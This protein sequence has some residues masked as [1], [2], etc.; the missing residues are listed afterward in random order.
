VT[1]RL[2]GKVALI[3]GTGGGQ[4]RAAAV[5]FAEEGAAVVGCDLK[6]EGNRE[7]VAMVKAAGGEMT[8]MEPVD[9]G[10]PEQAQKWVEQAA[11]V[12]GRIDILYNNASAPKFAPIPDLSVEDW[13]FTI[14]NELD[15][16]FYVTKY[17]WP[18]LAERGG[19]IISTASVAGWVGTKDTGLGAHA[20]AK[21]GVLALSRVFAADGA[22]HG[23]RAVT[24][25]PGPIET[26]GTAELFA[27]PQARDYLSSL[28]L[29][30]RFGKA[31][32]VA[33]LAVFL[34]SD[35]A[36]FIT[37]SDYIVDGGMTAI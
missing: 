2:E 15:L 6:E 3:T 5:R 36:G 17:A 37:G 27:N 34:A 19:V 22:A 18:H 31:D 1:K 29:A 35:D 23:I 11:A 32:D 26:P 10:D 8:G 28:L 14:R 24:I 20:A 16:V 21:G 4:G 25:S 33:A 30:P 13:Q 9:V 12:P 7:T